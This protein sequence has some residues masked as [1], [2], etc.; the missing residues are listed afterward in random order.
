MAIKPAYVSLLFCTIIFHGEKI[1]QPGVTRET[2]CFQTIPRTSVAGFS[3]FKKR[4]ME[5]V[6]FMWNGNGMG[7]SQI[8]IVAD[9]P[10]FC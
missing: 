5:G 1:A 3:G 8:V 6:C 2:C 9:W 10:D 7:M 4:V